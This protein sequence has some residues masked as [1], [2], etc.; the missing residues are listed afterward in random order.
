MAN[1]P[2]AGAHSNR[3]RQAVLEDVDFLADVVIAATRAQGR[4]PDDFAE[5]QLTGV[6]RP[7]W[8]K[9]RAVFD[10]STATLGNLTT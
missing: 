10:P 3:L 8:A 5:P 2:D 4:Q 7:P 6:S 9:A 1:H